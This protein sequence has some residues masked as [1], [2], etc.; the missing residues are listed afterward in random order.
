MKRRQGRVWRAA[1]SYA[2][3]LGL[4]VLWQGLYG[5][6]WL[7]EYLLGPSVIAAQFGEMVTSGELFGHL[8]SSLVRSYTGFL[9]GSL[10]GIG[11]GLLSGISR[12]AEDLFNPLISLTYPIPKIA[13]LPLILLWLGFGELSKVTIVAISSFYQVAISTFAG[14]RSVDPILVRAA[15]D[16]SA[17]ELQIL[18][19]VILP[20]ALPSV[21][22][23][24]RLG[25]GVSLI[26]VVAAEFVAAKF[27]IGYLIWSSAEIFQTERMMGGIIVTSVLGFG[28]T[29]ILKALE[30]AAIPWQRALKG[31]TH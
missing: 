21:F 25:L 2:S 17:S 11:L 20:A 8:R 14:V 12:R 9:A 6:G 13:I 29:L 5:L 7:P 15:M 22:A 16:C 28:F 30:R 31:E 10:L 1:Q 26:V 18:R 23:G 4:V 27:G 24:L 19:K 3:L